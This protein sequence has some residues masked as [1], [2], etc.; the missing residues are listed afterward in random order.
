LFFLQFVVSGVRTYYIYWKTRHHLRLS[1]KRL[2]RFAAD[3]RRPLPVITL[4]ICARNEALVIGQTIDSIMA[5][6]YPR[7]RF[8][9]MVVLDDKELSE[10]SLTATT[11]HV[12]HQKEQYYRE[13]FGRS[14]LMSTSVP[15]GFDGTLHGRIRTRSVPSTKPRA[16]NWVLPR[17]PEN[18]DII[19]I[20]DADSH[21]DPDTLLYVAHRWME[22]RGEP[23]I[24]QGPVVQVRNYHAL[25]AMNKFFALAQ[26]ITHEWFLPVLLQQLP[27]L[28][29]TNFFVDPQLL[30]TVGGFEPNSLTEDLELGCR[31]YIERDVWPEFLPYIA[32]EQTP[33]SYRSFF[34]QRIRWASGYLQVARQMLTSEGNL[35]K[36]FFLFTMLLLYGVFPWL[37]TQIFSVA[38]VGLVL[39]SFLGMTQ[40]LD[41]LP[42]SIRV[43]AVTMNTVYLLFMLVYFRHAV[44]KLY[45]PRRLSKGFL[46]SLRTYAGFC[47]V[48][49]AVLLGSLPYTY[50]FIISLLGFGPTGWV[51]T[52]RSS[53]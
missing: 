15:A 48:P 53:E 25:G 11:H 51:K 32:T 20:F 3:S 30:R 46:V 35:A 49:V 24:L 44:K 42:E 1:P 13:K 40:V 33:A 39:V 45:I 6:A 4:V 34:V 36:R 21:P 9:L 28:G 7:D 2:E 17:L 37:A 14:V 8:N 5:M 19:G 27:F 38:T 23:L 10:K 31:M 18:T 22:R 16:L 12:V 43:A 47:L 52:P 50:G 26:A 41:M 29:G